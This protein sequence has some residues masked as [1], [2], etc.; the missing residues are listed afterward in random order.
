MQPDVQAQDVETA[1]PSTR[2]ERKAAAKAESGPSE[3]A[4]P[5]ERHLRRR[6]ERREAKSRQPERKGGVVGRFVNTERFSGLTGFYQASMS[7][8]RKVQWPDQQTTINLTV[9][10]IALSTVLGLLL[11]GIDFVLFRLFEAMS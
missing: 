3:E 11:G 4:A 1:E 5:Q 2:A 8:I 7:E 6:Q 10:V 9:L